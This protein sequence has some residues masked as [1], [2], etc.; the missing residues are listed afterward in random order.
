MPKVVKHADGSEETLYTKEELDQGVKEAEEKAVETASAA[1]KKSAD[2]AIEK[3]KQEHPDQGDKIKTLEGTIN[4][5]NEKIKEAGGQPGDKKDKDD[6]PQVKRLRE[7]RDT[8][9]KA[10]DDFKEN[11]TKEIDSLKESAVSNVRDELLDKYSGGDAETRD[12]IKVEFDKYEPDKVSREDVARR[13][14]IAA[15]IVHGE[16]PTPQFLDNI[17]SGSGS[18]GD[19]PKGGGGK[20]KVTANAKAIG[21]VLGV[22]EE[23]LEKAEE[24]IKE[25]QENNKD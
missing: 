15:T 21:K 5:L 19:D 3:Y 22:S 23:E 17:G 6:S 16:K 25:M 18:R 20:E 1:A 14:E 11:I 24:Q 8:A 13:V 9:V 7:E 10:L 2:E 12:K 4:D